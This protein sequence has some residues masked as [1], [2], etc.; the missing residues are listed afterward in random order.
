MVKKK[1]SKKKGRSTDSDS[2]DYSPSPEGE[3]HRPTSTKKGMSK[4]NKRGHDTRNPPGQGRGNPP[5]KS[6]AQ[7]S[8]SALGHPSSP[9][10]EPEDDDINLSYLVDSMVSIRRP[11]R[12]R[13]DPAMVNYKR[14]GNFVENLRYSDDPREEQRNFHGDIRFWFPHQADWY[15]S[16]I[17]SYKHVTT[18]MK[19]IDWGYLKRLAS[20]VKEVVDVVYDRCKEMDLDNIMSFQCDWNEE[21]VEQFYATFFI[22][23]NERII[24]WHLGGKTF[25]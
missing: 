17:M 18:E 16:V 11:N 23:E 10:D 21:V 1:V 25:T 14:G 15:E 20:P 3:V 9:T 13:R 7:S 8:S 6:R 22:E 24:H 12:D 4:S 5:R 2:D 19:W